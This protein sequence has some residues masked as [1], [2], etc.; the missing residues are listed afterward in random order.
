MAA[1]DTGGEVSIR[2]QKRPVA[3]TNEAAIRE[4][5]RFVMIPSLR[6]GLS[7]RPR[8][9]SPGVWSAVR[10]RTRE[11]WRHASGSDRNGANGGLFREGGVRRGIRFPPRWGYQ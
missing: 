7:D 10:R 2:A 4:S 11:K 8:V 6:I 3:T 9:C 5:V 1:S